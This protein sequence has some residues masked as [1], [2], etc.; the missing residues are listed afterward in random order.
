M[1]RLTYSVSRKTRNQ[2]SQKIADTFEIWTK[3]VFQF[4]HELKQKVGLECS[5]IV[6]SSMKKNIIVCLCSRCYHMVKTSHDSLTNPGYRKCTTLSIRRAYIQLSTEWPVSQTTATWFC[7]NSDLKRS[8]WTSPGSSF[9]LF[10]FWVWSPL[11]TSACPMVIFNSCT[12]TNMARNWVSDPIISR[13]LPPMRKMNQLVF[14]PNDIA[15]S[16]MVECMGPCAIIPLRK[17]GETCSC[18]L[19]ANV[20]IIDPLIL[21]TCTEKM[22]DQV[23]WIT[24][25]STGIGAA[26]A[27]ESAKLGSK[28]VISARSK[29]KL[30]QVRRQCLGNHIHYLGTNI[31]LENTPCCS[32]QRLGNL[33]GL[34][35]PIFL[36]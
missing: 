35:M 12:S 7:A 2:T 18:V 4:H 19:S 31:E 17:H 1:I 24:G 36:C 26:L 27:I 32:L 29:E 23:V 6:T 33:M 3:Y 9:T 34:K 21:L 22:K 5:C 8:T 28:I 14:W 11:C 13:P 20:L 30:E 10:W 25:A 15:Q 16:L